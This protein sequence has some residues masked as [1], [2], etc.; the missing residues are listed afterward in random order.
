MAL[1]FFFFLGV[2]FLGGGVT[3]NLPL[4]KEQKWRINHANVSCCR[5]TMNPSAA[6][7]PLVTGRL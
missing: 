2:C 5:A 6:T 1:L 4:R 7:F 3:M